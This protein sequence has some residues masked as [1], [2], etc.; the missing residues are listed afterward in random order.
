MKIVYL[1]DSITEWFHYLESHDNVSNFGISGNTIIDLIGRV[2]T[3]FDKK[4]DR[5]LIMIG[6]NDYLRKNNYWGN[7]L[8]TNINMMYG[9]LLKL[10]HDNLPDTEVYCLSI[11]PVSVDQDNIQ[12]NDEIVKLNRYINTLTRSYKYNYVDLHKHFMDSEGLHSH[13]TTD[14]VHLSEKGYDLY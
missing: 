5:I 2:E 8:K 9:I 10:I 12:F 3:V 14:G 6:I 13:Y 4:P 1:G 7:T 11:L